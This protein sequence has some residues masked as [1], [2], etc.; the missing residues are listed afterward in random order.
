M[1]DL[2]VQIIQVSNNQSTDIRLKMHTNA[3]V[4]LLNPKMLFKQYP[5]PI[6]IINLKAPPLYSLILLILFSVLAISVIVC[7]VVLSFSID[8]I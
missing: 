8:L 1:C 3:D 4:L 5:H 6:K 7:A 2:S